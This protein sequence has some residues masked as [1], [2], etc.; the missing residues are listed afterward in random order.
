METLTIYSHL[1]YRALK[2]EDMI[3]ASSKESF[4]SVSEIS[5]FACYYLVSV[6]A[7]HSDMYLS[8]HLHHLEDSYN[9]PH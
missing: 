5:I 6:V 7:C 3:N 1:V 9:K 8:N 4:L 2:S